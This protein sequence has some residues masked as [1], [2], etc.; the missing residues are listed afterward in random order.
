VTTRGPGGSGWVLEGAR[1]SGA[2]RRGALTGGPR[3][4][5]HAAAVADRWARMAQCQAAR[6]QTG[7]KNISNGF[8]NSPN[9]D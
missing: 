8:K 4:Q 5:C 9:F 3:P 2:T 7:F 6:I 1:A